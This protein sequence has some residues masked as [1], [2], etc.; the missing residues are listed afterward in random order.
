M[1]KRRVFG[2]LGVTALGLAFFCGPVRANVIT[3]WDEKA[4]AVVSPMGPTGVTQQVLHGSAYDGDGPRRDVRRGQFDR[5]AL[6]AVSGAAACGRRHVEGS[7]RCDGCR[8][9]T[10]DN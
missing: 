3:D 5:A 9:G 2:I 6:P 1:N 10:G 7:C 8:C 4:V